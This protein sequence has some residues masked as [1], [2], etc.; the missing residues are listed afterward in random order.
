MR[1]RPGKT[2]GAP[3]RLVPIGGAFIGPLAWLIDL[4]LSTLLVPHVCET[5]QRGPLIWVGLAA[6]LGTAVGSLLC[7][8]MPSDPEPGSWEE[9]EDRP[10]LR[11]SIVVAGVGLNAL[12]GLLILALMMPKLMLDPCRV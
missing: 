9:A 10:D 12:S 11:A 3:S 5:G 2:K 4:Q 1:A 7:W 8:R 6:L